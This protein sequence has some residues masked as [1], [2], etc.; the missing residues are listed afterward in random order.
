MNLQCLYHDDAMNYTRLTFIT[1]P[2]CYLTLALIVLLSNDTYHVI[3]IFFL[4]LG[5]AEQSFC[6]W[7]LQLLSSSCCLSLSSLSLSLLSCLSLCSSFSPCTLVCQLQ[8]HAC[9][10][11]SAV[12]HLCWFT[13]WSSNITQVR[14]QLL[15][16]LLVVHQFCCLFSVSLIWVLDFA[17]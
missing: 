6:K 4:F 2:Q 7:S 13:V 5:H 11:S 9:S 15:L 16:K 1:S 14:T 3:S 8:F 12:C 17:I 10:Q